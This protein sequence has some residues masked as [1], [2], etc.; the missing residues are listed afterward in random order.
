MRPTTLRQPDDQSFSTDLTAC[1]L[2]NASEPRI[3]WTPFSDLMSSLS[4][5]HAITGSRLLSDG[6]RNAEEVAVAKAGSRCGRL[7]TQCAVDSAS[8]IQP[9]S[10]KQLMISMVPAVTP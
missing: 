10:N 5:A 8:G 6:Q 4:T 1:L 2:T 3:E 7:L 9:N